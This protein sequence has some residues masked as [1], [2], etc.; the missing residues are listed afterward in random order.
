MKC[1][2]I[3]LPLKNHNYDTNNHQIAIKIF[4]KLVNMGLGE[5]ICF[6]E[7]LLNLQLSEEMYIL[8]LCST[9]QKPTLFLKR[10]ANDIQTNVYGRHA[11]P[12]WEPNIDAQ[13][14]LDPYVGVSYCTTYLTKV[15]KSIPQKMQLVLE[16]CKYE[17]IETFECIKI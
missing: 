4:Q 2:Q 14:I 17:K 6:D 7:F 15:D 12:L 16:K 11:K 5:D 8:A 9:L 3:L 10:K 1:T 13:F